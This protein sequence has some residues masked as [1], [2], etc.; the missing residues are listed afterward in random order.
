VIDPLPEAVPGERIEPFELPKLAQRVLAR[1]TLVVRTD[2]STELGDHV[3]DGIAQAWRRQ[4]ESLTAIEPAQVMEIKSS[5][6]AARS[7]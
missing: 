2:R 6:Q 1:G 3:R 5:V 4:I 7:A